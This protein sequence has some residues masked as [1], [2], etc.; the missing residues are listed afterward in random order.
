MPEPQ[1]TTINSEEFEALLE[2]I[3]RDQRPRGIVLQ[4]VLLIVRTTDANRTMW[5]GE[6][7]VLVTGVFPDQTMEVVGYQLRSVDP[8]NVAEENRRFIDLLELLL[9][10]TGIRK[11]SGLTVAIRDVRNP[12]QT[13]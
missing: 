11:V 8:A 1:L 13:I 5:I 7:S 6:G 4:P 9:D 10:R 2:S 12:T 3:A